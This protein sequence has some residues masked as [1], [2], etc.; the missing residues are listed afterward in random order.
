MADIQA[1]DGPRE[2]LLLPNSASPLPA[3]FPLS[4]GVI[5]MVFLSMMVFSCFAWKDL[6]LYSR[7]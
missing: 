4:P 7:A 5:G 2:W 3:G 1:A 6:I